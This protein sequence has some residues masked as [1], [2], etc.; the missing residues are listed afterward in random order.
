[1]SPDVGYSKLK[2]EQLKM[3]FTVEYEYV[4][5]MTGAFRKADGSL[6]CTDK[7]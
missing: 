2:Y 4:I 1:V 3:L 6:V 5:Q 7:T